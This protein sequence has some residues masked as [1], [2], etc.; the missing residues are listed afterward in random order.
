MLLYFYLR[1]KPNCKHSTHASHVPP[2]FILCR[3]TA[4]KMQRFLESKEIN[5]HHLNN[6]GKEWDWEETFLLCC[7]LPYS[8]NTPLTGLRS[9]KAS[10]LSKYFQMCLLPNPS[11]IAFPCS[12]EALDA[13]N[14][15]EWLITLL[16]GLIVLVPRK[17]HPPPKNRGGCGKNGITAF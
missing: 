9:E 7:Q 15:T 5:L 16:S 2:R 17:K 11:W 12:K 8:L 14:G 1:V 10:V 3:G 4:G 13:K 6:K